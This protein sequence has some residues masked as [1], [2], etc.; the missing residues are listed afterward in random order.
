MNDPTQSSDDDHAF[1][2]QDR[3]PSEV[4]K[5]IKSLD[6]KGTK[7]AQL[8]ARAEAISTLLDVLHAMDIGET[9]G[10]YYDALAI[11][12]WRDGQLPPKLR[13]RPKD[14]QEDRR[15]KIARKI[16][17]VERYYDL[18]HPYDPKDV[19]RRPIE[20]V[21]DEFNVEPEV[22]ERVLKSARPH[23]AELLRMRHGLSEIHEMWFEWEWMREKGLVK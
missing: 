20:Q 15:D 1:D 11:Q 19:A 6:N 23:K 2:P 10:T 22:V 13:G 21:A 3:L 5:A 18:M 7:D 9:A 14:F 8:A 16:A 4:F 12:A 17:I